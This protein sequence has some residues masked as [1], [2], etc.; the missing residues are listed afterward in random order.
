MLVELEILKQSRAFHGLREPTTTEKELW[1][2][3]AALWYDPPHGN[4]ESVKAELEEAGVLAQVQ[5]LR[6][7]FSTS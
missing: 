7:Q 2:A 3:L 1:W 5:P 6:E 4:S